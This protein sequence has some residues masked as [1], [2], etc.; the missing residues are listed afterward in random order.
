LLFVGVVVVVP[1][2]IVHDAAAAV[3]GACARATERVVG[4]S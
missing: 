2:V 1:L 4:V 3:L